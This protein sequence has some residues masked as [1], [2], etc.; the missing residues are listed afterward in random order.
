VLSR[1][2]DDPPPA[3]PSVTDRPAH[4]ATRI[5]PTSLVVLRRPTEIMIIRSTDPSGEPFLRLPGGGI[6]PGERA[7]QAAVR[8]VR[9]EVGATLVNPRLLGVVENIFRTGNTAS[10]HELYFVISGDLAE[11][12]FSDPGWSGLVRGTGQPLAWLTETDLR[13]GSTPFHPAAVLDL[14][15]DRSTMYR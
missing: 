9:E 11:A 7:V 4:R 6:E 14:I 2:A 13:A 12:G 1:L 15:G 5:R 8:E 10:V 3:D